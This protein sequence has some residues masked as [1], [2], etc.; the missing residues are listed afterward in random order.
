MALVGPPTRARTV[1]RHPSLQALP[2]AQRVAERVFNSV[3]RFLHVEVVS[4]VVLLLTAAAAL[5]LATSPAAASYE[6]FWHL[7]VTLGFAD[8]SY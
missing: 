2:C 8:Y 5:I 3:E 1:S 6:H 7:L 4:G